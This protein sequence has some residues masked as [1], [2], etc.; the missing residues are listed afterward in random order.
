MPDSTTTRTPQVEAQNSFSYEYG[1]DVKIGDQWQPIRFITGVNPSVEPKEQDGATYDDKG[2]PH[3]IKTGEEP[4]LE[5]SQQSRR[6]A[7]GN[8][9]PETEELLKATKPG[10]TGNKAT[11]IVRYYDKPASGKPNPGD[12]YELTGTVSAQRA[13]TGNDALAALN[14]TIKGQGP[15]RQIANPYTPPAENPGA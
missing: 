3:P 9:L 8:Y 11:V 15:R 14:F 7:D 13:E 2:A 4:Q 6:L 10:A 1:V 12:A 5:F